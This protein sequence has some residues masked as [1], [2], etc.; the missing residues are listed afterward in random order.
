[1]TKFKGFV[2]PNTKIFLGIVYFILAIIYIADRLLG[3][4]NIRLFDW[5]GWIA[6]FTAGAISI[7]EGVK[8]K[9]NNS[10]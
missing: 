3:D 9:K 1:M 5:I 8:I 6:M 2:G 10:L 7:I 4:L